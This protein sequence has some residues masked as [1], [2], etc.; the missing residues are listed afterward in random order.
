MDWTPKREIDECRNPDGNFYRSRSHR[1][2]KW[3]GEQMISRWRYWQHGSVARSHTEAET[4]KKKTEREWKRDGRIESNWK[5]EWSAKERR[6]NDAGRAKITRKASFKLNRAR[7]Q[8]EIHT[9]YRGKEFWSCIE[10]VL[11][12]RKIILINVDLKKIS[13]PIFYFI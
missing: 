3:A 2:R 9:A 5:R 13:F 6:G 7:L 10:S 8:L 12:N 4:E 11:E 1:A